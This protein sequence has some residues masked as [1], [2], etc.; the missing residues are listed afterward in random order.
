M[1]I[2]TRKYKTKMLRT[3]II[4]DE[5][6]V[7]RTLEKLVKVHCP[8][9]KLIGEADGIESGVRIIKKHHP[10][11]VLLDIKMNDGS[12]FDLLKELEPVDF[13]VI[14][15]TAYDQYA[16]KA[17]KFSALDYLLKPVNPDDLKMAVDKAEKLLVSELNQ[18][19]DAL[20]DNIQTSDREKKKIILKTFDNIHLVKLNDIVYCESNDNYTNFHLLNNKTIL[21]SNTLKEYDDMLAEFGFFRI[22]KSYLINLKHI[23]RFEKVDGGSIVLSNE[24][25]LPVASRKKEHLMEMLYRITKN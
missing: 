14:F 4:D 10:D 18:Q 12:G 11:L 9:I 24:I 5:E 16:L 15:I 6:N 3:I 21:V 20:A 2:F 13:K 17:I 19:L 25:K 23:E 1:T 22:H 8:T 7:R